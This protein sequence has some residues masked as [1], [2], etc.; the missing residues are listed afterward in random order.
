M[1]SKSTERRSTSVEA[2]REAQQETTSTSVEDYVSKSSAEST[3]RAYKSDV[4]HYL[5]HAGTIP[6]SPNEIAAYIAAWA[7][8][9][10]VATLER[11][12]IAL[13]QEH[14][15]KGLPTP[16]RDPLVK[17]TMRGIRR[18]KGRQQ[19]QVQ[20]IE[21]DDL[22][23]MLAVAE[24]Q[25]PMKAARDK[26]LLLVGFAGA[27]RRSELVALTVADLTER[28][29][30]MEVVIRRS[31]T[32]QEGEGRLVF[33]PRATG[34]RC[35]VL[36]LQEWLLLAAIGSG[37]IFRSVNRHDQIRRQGLLAQAVATIIKQIV[38]KTGRDPKKFAGHSLRAGFVTTAAVQGV[39]TW[40]IK[41]QTGHK[42]DA[43][44]AKYIRPVHRRKL[45]SLL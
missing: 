36:A 41:E 37:P 25:A 42:S 24:Q 45:P 31:K 2:N 8:R 29:E 27:F 19:R 40:Q 30:G 17:R 3:K 9:L 26:A 39:P 21:K 6:A 5:K 18:V 7:D 14:R 22:L 33:L 13:H 11:R 1:S 4:D 16:V 34:K 20:A 23:E 32:D 43:I 12:L 15:A 10:S 44:L 35:P 28:S 38:A